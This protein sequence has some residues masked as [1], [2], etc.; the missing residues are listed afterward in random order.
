MTLLDNFREG[1]GDNGIMRSPLS[2]ITL[3]DLYGSK[4]FG[5]ISGSV[6]G[7]AQGTR[8]LLAFDFN[9]RLLVIR[10]ADSA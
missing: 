5:V 6:P 8:H 2:A 4:H 7:N 1:D 9:D 10:H 3:L